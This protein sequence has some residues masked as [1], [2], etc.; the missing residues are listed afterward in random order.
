MRLKRPMGLDR[1]SDRHLF[2]DTG[3]HV[4]MRCFDFKADDHRGPNG[5]VPRRT[6]I[7]CGHREE[8]VAANLGARRPAS[9]SKEPRTVE[10]QDTFTYPED[11]PHSPT[12]PRAGGRRS[13]AVYTFDIQYLV[14]WIWIRPD[15]SDLEVLDP[16]N[17]EP[18]DSSFASLNSRLFIAVFRIA[19]IY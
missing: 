2:K 11:Q 10:G 6:T 17:R 3:L 8:Y 18:T 12:G 9:E 16:H 14:S 19:S 7:Q 4:F 13:M 15:D 5:F 1:P